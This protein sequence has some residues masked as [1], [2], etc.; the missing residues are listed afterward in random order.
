MPFTR[1]L[2]TI[3]S[4]LDLGLAAYTF[5]TFPKWCQT[6]HR[7]AGLIPFEELPVNHWRILHPGG[8]T[9]CIGGANVQDPRFG[10]AIRRGNTDKV[11]VDFQ[12]G[13][14]CWSHMT[15]NAVAAGFKMGCDV[16]REFDCQ[17]GSI[18]DGKGGI[19]DQTTANNPFA[20]DTYIYV[21]YCTQVLL[22]AKAN[23][24]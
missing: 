22:L 18:L 7:N 12:G 24:P 21:P 1:L 13:G 16:V 23:M 15:C 3:A 17:P 19:I 11:V 8:I 4:V 10:F 5:E 6:N 14:A 9:G 2:L 20:Q